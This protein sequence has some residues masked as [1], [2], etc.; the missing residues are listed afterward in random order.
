M[1]RGQTDFDP[2]A[3]RLLRSRSQEQG[4]SAEQLATLVGATKAQIIA[5]EN[6]RQTPDGPRIRRLAE[7]LGVAP[8]ELMRLEN[9]GHWSV[10]DWRRSAGLRVQDV[11]TAL[12]ISPKSYR[13]FEAEGIVPSRRPCFLDD[14]A[15]LFSTDADELESALLGNPI[16]RQRARKAGELIQSLYERYVS[17]M[18]GFWVGPSETDE[19]IRE[20]AQLYGRTV[21]GIT[22]LLVQELM[23]LR[24]ALINTI[25]FGL[26]QHLELTKER[27][28]RATRE[29]DGRRRLLANRLKRLPSKLERFYW[30][31]LPSDSWQLIVDLY[32]TDPQ[33]ADGLWAVTTDWSA[34]AGIDALPPSMISRR[35]FDGIACCKLTPTGHGF[36]T[37]NKQMY[38]A[39]HP[40]V[41][42]V[43]P[44]R[45]RRPGQ[46]PDGARSTVSSEHVL[47]GLP[48][49][50][51]QVLFQRPLPS[52][53]AVRQVL[54]T[55]PPA[56][57]GEPRP[58][59]L[60]IS[61]GDSLF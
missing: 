58:R 54:L 49:Q 10:A 7:A 41:S 59:T 36:V 55:A 22:R 5:Y 16:L 45:A 47:L 61:S 39:Y 57:P 30:R 42:P 44:F 12:S 27:R 13:R 60:N 34:A 9:Q 48:G 38:A 28:E 25:R 23:Q 29:A 2:M 37:R 15:S 1:A 11:V 53:P 33:G 26:D 46:S 21:S 31:L 18:E 50:N 52:A 17:Q 3:L 35:E 43:R 14:L 40:T 51:V 32:N 56:G 8:V 24:R 4:M 20:L 19:E 6:G